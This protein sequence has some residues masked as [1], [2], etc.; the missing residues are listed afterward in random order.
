MRMLPPLVRFRLSAVACVAVLALAAACAAASTAHIQAKAARICPRPS[1]GSAVPEPRDVRS[2]NGVLTLALELRDSRAADGT[3]RY[4]YL[5]PDGSEA[6]TLRVRPGDLLIVRLSNAL[7]DP[8]SPPPARRTRAAGKQEDMCTSGAMAPTAT[9]LHFHG[10]AVP[11]ICH[12]DEVMKTSIPSKASFEYRFR[13]PK[14]QPPG[15]YWYHPHIHGFSMRAVLAGASGALVVEGLERATP[16]VAGLP[17]RV[18]VMRDQ[19]LMNPD[20]PPSPTEPVT[21]QILL[22]PDGDTINT[23]TGYGK[24]AKDLSVNFVPVPYPDYP[25]AVI[26]LRPGER[27]L[28]RVLN[29]SAITYLHLAVLFGATAQPLGLVAID[30]VPINVSGKDA[31]HV[32][33]VDHIGVPPGGRAEFIIT[34]PPASVPASLITRSVDTGA[35]GD[36]DPN[37]IL[38]T[39]TTRADAPEPRSSLDAHP[40]PGPERTGE[41]LG[42][43]EPVRVRKLFFSELHANPADPQSPITYFITEQGKEPKPFDPAASEPDIV[44]RQGDVEDWVIENRTTELHAFHIHQIHFLLLDWFG[45]PV[46]EPFLRDTVNVPFYDPQMGRFP[47]VRVR[48]DFRDPNTVGTFLYHCHVLEHEDGGMMGVIRVEPRPGAQNPSGEQTPAATQAGP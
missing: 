8:G 12:Q 45:L 46:R 47:S 20:A 30:G 9:N 2:R 39:L 34:A 15:L 33:W 28:W 6:P 3:L 40:P 32:E 21:P 16:E 48:M 37:R 11:P 17:E 5:L 44:V 27:Q 42:N 26:T 24:P 43:L 19:Y 41:W 22:D 10:L 25:P 35:S 14:D 7:A 1:P 23:H 13:V 29:A 31:P 36:N 18:L 4:C 38:A